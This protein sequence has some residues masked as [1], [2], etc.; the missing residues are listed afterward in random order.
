M[1]KTKS[2]VY[3]DGVE[4]LG[5]A[6]A[7]SGRCVAAYC[8]RGSYERLR[9]LDEDPMMRLFVTITATVLL[10]LPA[11]C[12]N[13]NFGFLTKERDQPVQ[14]APPT[15]EAVVAYLNENAN[16]IQSFRSD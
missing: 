12:T 7:V 11:G 14:G 13:T 10:A 9:R 2:S 1:C 4:N 16:R 8:V 5:T 3:W 15:K 6:H